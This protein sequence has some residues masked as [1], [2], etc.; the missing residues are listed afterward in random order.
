M[1]RKIPLLILSAAAC[2]LL[3]QCGLE[4]SITPWDAPTVTVPSIGK[5]VFTTG[6][7]NYSGGVG[8][9]SFFLGYELYYKAADSASTLSADISL[10]D[11]NELSSHQF[12][13]MYLSSDVWEPASAT[14]PAPLVKLIPASGDKVTVTL[15]FNKLTAHGLGMEEATASYEYPVGT[16]VTVNLR[17]ALHSNAP[18]SSSDYQHFKRFNAFWNGDN[19]IYY[20]GIPLAGVL[21]EAAL[22][23]V[24]LI[25]IYAYGYNIDTGSYVRSSLAGGIVNVSFYCWDEDTE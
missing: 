10:A 8:T 21:N 15:D 17:R 18:Q 16:P 3:A 24:I 6:D 4:R 13:R 12:Q 5:F 14:A 22:P 20:P 25:Y 9:N 11:A 2:L 19:D 23:A 1:R 7:N